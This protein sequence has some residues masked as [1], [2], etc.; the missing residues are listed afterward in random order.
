MHGWLI[1]NTNKSR[2]FRKNARFEGETASKQTKTLHFGGFHDKSENKSVSTGYAKAARKTNKQLINVKTWGWETQHKNLASDYISLF[3]SLFLG[4]SCLCGVWF[5]AVFI[6][7]HI[8]I[9][10]RWVLWHPMVH[11][12]PLGHTASVSS[13]VKSLLLSPRI[14]QIPSTEWNGKI[15]F[16]PPDLLTIS[17]KCYKSY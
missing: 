7:L 17:A 14:T 5:Q 15:C 3:S 13:G 6:T 1:L 16:F 10:I 9:N 12:D 2:L 4:W 11:A 8:L